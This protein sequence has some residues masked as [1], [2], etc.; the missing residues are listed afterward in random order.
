MDN[1]EKKRQNDNNQPKMP[2][3]NMNWIYTVILISLGILFITG[4]AAALAV[5]SSAK[6]EATSTKIKE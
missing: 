4:G 2:K 1:N 5:G 3:F 6:Q